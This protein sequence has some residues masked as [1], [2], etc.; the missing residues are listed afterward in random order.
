M[1]F[2]LKSLLSITVITT[3]C[4]QAGKTPEPSLN[5]TVGERSHAE[6]VQR[7]EADPDF[8]EN[9]HRRS[10]INQ[11]W[12]T[13]EGEANRKMALTGLSVLVFG[14]LVAYIRSHSS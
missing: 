12:A 3:F 10:E 13:H 11:Y 1:K 14:G 9:E 7:L 8:R 4:L 5:Q 6:Y 2:F